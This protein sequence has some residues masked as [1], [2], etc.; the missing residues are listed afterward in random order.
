MKLVLEH[1][2]RWPNG[3]CNHKIVITYTKYN[4][5]Y[6]YL[7]LRRMPNVVKLVVVSHAKINIAFHC[8][9]SNIDEAMEHK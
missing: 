3:I 1:L 9:Y 2:K 7:R 4:T 5:I 6:H 8:K